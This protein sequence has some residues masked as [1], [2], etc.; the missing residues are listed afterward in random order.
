MRSSPIIH[1]S[2]ILIALLMVISVFSSNLWLV[3]AS[4]DISPLTDM[5]LVKRIWS[6]SIEKKVFTATINW[7]VFEELGNGLY[8]LWLP[9][10]VSADAFGIASA[11]YIDRE[12]SGNGFTC[13]NPGPYIAFIREGKTWQAYKGSRVIDFADVDQVLSRVNV[14]T[15]NVLSFLNA[16]KAL[17]AGIITCEELL[18]IVVSSTSKLEASTIIKAV[19][20]YLNTPHVKIAIIE[21]ATSTYS[22]LPSSFIEEVKSKFGSDIAFGRS[23]IGEFIIIR[24][25]YIKGVAEKYGV[26]ERE[27]VNKILYELFSLKTAPKL[28]PGRRLLIIMDPGIRLHSTPLPGLTEE[29]LVEESEEDIKLNNTNTSA[30]LFTN[31]GQPSKT[32]RAYNANSQGPNLTEEPLIEESE[33][34]IK[35]NNT[36]TP[37]P[38]FTNGGESS[39]TSQ[40]NKYLQLQVLA[41]MS[42]LGA[43]LAASIIA[44]GKRK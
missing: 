27:A 41:V 38:L 37:V 9:D 10:N 4:N 28:D 19:K 23:L 44:K 2:S 16:T 24:I 43:L 32:N 13:N 7:D 11:L 20:S 40:E 31:G 22:V 35:F 3:K 39:K 30:P 5:D 8:L 14:R 26:S 34:G 25:G 42:V 15:S 33:E 36:N 6:V 17:D 29:L 1:V 12:M 18:Q 21:T